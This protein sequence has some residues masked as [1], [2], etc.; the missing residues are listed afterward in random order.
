LNL[1]LD[2]PTTEEDKNRLFIHLVY[3]PDDIPRQHIQKLYGEHCSELLRS[4]IGIQ[5]PTIAYKRP[6]NV[7]DF[8]THAK[9][10]EAPGR[11]ASIIMGEFSAGLAPL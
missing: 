4:V 9:L 6:K 7:G 1:V 2:T 5:R 11:T 3:H 10:H 8:I